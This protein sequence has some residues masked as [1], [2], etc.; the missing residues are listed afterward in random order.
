MSAEDARIKK[1][2]AILQGK[3][4]LNALEGFENGQ[5]PTY[6]DWRQVGTKGNTIVAVSKKKVQQF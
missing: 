1:G 3:T 5:S 2:T 4:D 6:K